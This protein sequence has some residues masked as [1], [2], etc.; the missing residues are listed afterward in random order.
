MGILMPGWLMVGGVVVWLVGWRKTVLRF[1]SLNAGCAHAGAGVITEA[2][3]RP[4]V[5]VVPV[6]CKS[7]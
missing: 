3:L 4:Q 6:V 2:V 5:N 7:M 1:L